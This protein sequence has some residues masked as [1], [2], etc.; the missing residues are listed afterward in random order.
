[1]Q[2]LLL[3]FLNAVT[4]KVLIAITMHLS[5]LK[6]LNLYKSTG[7]TEDGAH[8]IVRNLPRLRRFAVESTHVLFTNLVLRLWKDT[9]P[10]LD[11]SEINRCT[12][13]CAK[14]HTW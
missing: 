14:L 11:I 10:E 1:L 3:A 7:Y 6:S 8:A 9:L 4:D 2:D 13:G 5:Q 12:P